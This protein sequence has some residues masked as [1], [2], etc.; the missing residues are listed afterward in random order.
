MGFTE[1]SLQDHVTSEHAETS[2]EVVSIRPS[3]SRGPAGAEAGPR[4]SGEGGARSHGR[5]IPGCWTGSSAQVSS[6]LQLDEVVLVSSL[7]GG[8]G[9]EGSVNTPRPSAMFKQ[10]PGE[11]VQVTGA[12]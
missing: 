12:L 5:H 10:R 7:S 3:R 1:T 11:C 4:E 6:P 2:T 8:G 9:S